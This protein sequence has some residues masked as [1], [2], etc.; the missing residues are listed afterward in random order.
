MKITKLKLYSL[1]QSQDGRFYALKPDVYIK[2]KNIKDA[3]KLADEYTK[4][5][6]SKYNG[7]FHLEETTLKIYG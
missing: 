2:A 7:F 5:N 4:G 3:R 6:F 1:I